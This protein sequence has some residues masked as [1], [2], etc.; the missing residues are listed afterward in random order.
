MTEENLV[1]AFATEASTTNEKQW[2]PWFAWHPVR[3]LGGKLVWMK[4]VERYWNPKVDMWMIHP[5][6]RGEYR[7]GWEYRLPSV[8]H[9]LVRPK[10]LENS[11][12]A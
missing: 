10:A 8:S 7:G 9:K 1:C 4:K 11:A 2:R 5:D 3:T 6:D 12:R